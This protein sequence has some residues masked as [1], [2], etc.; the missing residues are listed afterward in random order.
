MVGEFDAARWDMDAAERKA[1]MATREVN[2]V[3]NFLASLP[4]EAT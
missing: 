3:P 4:Y 1:L 2:Q